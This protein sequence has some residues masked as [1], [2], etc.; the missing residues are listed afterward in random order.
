[1]VTLGWLTVAYS[2]QVKADFD[3]TINL[4]AASKGMWLRAESVT[5]R[6]DTADYNRNRCQ[7]DLR[8]QVGNAT[9]EPIT[10]APGSFVILLEKNPK[11]MFLTAM[12]SMKYTSFQKMQLKPGDSS[13]VSVSFVLPDTGRSVELKFTPV[14]SKESVW[15]TFLPEVLSPCKRQARRMDLFLFALD[16]YRR[17]LDTRQIG[18]FWGPGLLLL[19]FETEGAKKQTCAEVSTE[20]VAVLDSLVQDMAQ[21]STRESVIAGNMEFTESLKT[22]ISGAE[23]DARRLLVEYSQTRNSRK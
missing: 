12:G 20:R 1:M 10:V 23:S 8:L 7:L 14:G 22:T 16:G 11:S 2:S 5:W 4:K 21:E 18:K 17:F 15:L 6:F 13:Y 3:D 9:K 19:A